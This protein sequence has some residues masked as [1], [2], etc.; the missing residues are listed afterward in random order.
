MSY[1]LVVTCKVHRYQVAICTGT[2]SLLPEEAHDALGPLGGLS[3]CLLFCR[4]FLLDN[5][6]LGTKGVV[7]SG[8]SALHLHPLAGLV[9]I[10]G[11]DAAQSLGPGL[12]LLLGQVQLLL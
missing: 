12:D 6:L 10:L 4:H 9:L 2:S 5:V 7:L 3:Q 8:T 1:S 11:G